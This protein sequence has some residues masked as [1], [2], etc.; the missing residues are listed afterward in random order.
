MSDDQTLENTGSAS[1][2]RVEEPSVVKLLRKLKKI[3]F[4]NMGGL[5]KRGNLSEQEDLL[6][7]VV[8]RCLENYDET[9]YLRAEAPSTAALAQSTRMSNNS[10][11]HKKLLKTG[12]YVEAKEGD[13]TYLLFTDQGLMKLAGFFADKISDAK[14]PVVI[15]PSVR[16][17]IEKA[18]E[19]QGM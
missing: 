16:D 19:R 13:K 17:L 14:T 18:T 9:G 7:Y 6:K 8:C 12:F 1:P 15:Q 10:E 2:Q 4:H 5:L 11:A 3:N